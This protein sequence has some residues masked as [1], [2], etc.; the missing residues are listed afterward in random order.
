M[1]GCCGPICPGSGAD[2]GGG[3]ESMLFMTPS[4]V[5]LSAT[6]IGG[7]PDGPLKGE[8]RNPGPGEKEGTKAAARDTMET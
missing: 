4:S 1:G 3:K 6:A 7:C 2:G 8:R 5:H